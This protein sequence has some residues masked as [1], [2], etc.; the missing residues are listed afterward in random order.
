MKILEE[1]KKE[2]IEQM[3]ERIFAALPKKKS[4]KK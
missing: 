4:F 3:R 1:Q 2:F